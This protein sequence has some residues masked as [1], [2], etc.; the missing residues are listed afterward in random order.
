MS[1]VADHLRKGLRS[2]RAA[3]RAQHDVSLAVSKS[4]IERDIPV[5]WE[6]D[7][8]LMDYVNRYMLK[9]S[10]AGFVTSPYTSAFDLVWGV[11][12]I[13]DLP[14]YKD[15]YT[16]VPY[17]KAAIDVTVNLAISNGFELDGGDDKVQEWLTDWLDEQNI[18]RTLRMVATDMLVFGNAFLEICRDEDTGEIAWLKGLDPVY[19]RPRRDAYGNVFGYIQLLT[20]PPVVFTAQDMVHFKWGAKSWWFENAFGTSL[21]RPLLKIQA[22]INQFENDMATICH[23]YTKPMLV[24]KAG[25]PEKPLGDDKVGELMGMFQNRKPATDLFVRGDVLVEPIPSMTKDINVEFWL[26]YLYKE[27]E[28]VL[29]VPKIFLGESEGANRA[30]ADVVMQEYV[31][32]LRMMQ[33]IIGDVLETTLFKQLI[34]DQFGDGQEIPHVTWKPIWEAK[35]EDKAKYVQGLVQAGIITVAEARLELGYAAKPAEGELP[36]Q[37]TQV[38]DKASPMGDTGND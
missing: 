8:P 32:R 26:N 13:E 6:K 17:I 3:F 28:A 19:M 35:V 10:G 38:N 30:T 37:P 36:K 16:F 18:L 23:T 34:D 5:T 14:K 4:Q 20:M 22:L 9:G 27:R 33:E 1:L 31:T 21:L 15:L 7:N 12:P 24:I 2:L 25:T 29:G 11:T